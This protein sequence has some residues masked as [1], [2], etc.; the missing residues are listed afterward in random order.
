MA[1]LKQ[2]PLNARGEFFLWLGFLLPVAAWS[3]FLEALYL[4][5]ERACHGGSLL[6]NHI[7]AIIALVTAL[8]GGAIS[9]RLQHAG[10][11]W[12]D[13]QPDP[14]TRRRFIAV[15]G[16]LNAALFSILIFAQ[17]LPTLLGV[18]CDK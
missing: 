10:W 12:P 8:L 18:P 1:E 11:R 2:E 9:F 7:A 5:T 3:I 15:L 14:L 13:Q 17:W 4:L 16:L 6:P